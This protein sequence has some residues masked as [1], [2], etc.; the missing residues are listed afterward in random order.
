[1]TTPTLQDPLTVRVRG[2]VSLPLRVCETLAV[3]SLV[4]RV[5]ATEAEYAKL[6][7]GTPPLEYTL[8]I[9]MMWEA[10]REFAGSE[11]H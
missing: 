7:E 5:L 11:A 9:A 8:E 2:A 3:G 4:S 1:M 6:G 10:V